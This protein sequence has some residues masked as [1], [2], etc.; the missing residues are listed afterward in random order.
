VRLENTITK[1]EI[2][3]NRMNITNTINTS[4]TNNINST[5]K[6]AKW[7]VLLI[8]FLQLLMEL[9]Y[10]ISGSNYAFFIFLNFWLSMTYIKKRITTGKFETRLFLKSILVSV[11]YFVI[12]MTVSKT[13]DG[14]GWFQA[15]MELMDM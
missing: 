10:D 4:L 12:I 2:E 15:N 14:I 11:M 13:V 8:C 3:I 6:K 7:G 9:V 5:W 1:S